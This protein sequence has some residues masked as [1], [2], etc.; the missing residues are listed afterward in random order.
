MSFSSEVKNEVRNNR[1]TTRKRHS[2]MSRYSRKKEQPDRERII[3]SFLKAGTVSDPG[4]FYHLEFICETEDEAAAL[5]EAIEGFG[6]SPGQM[7][8]KDREVLYFK[9][10]ESISDILVILGATNALLKLRDIMVL[11]EMKEYV[12]RRVNCET[13][14]IRKTVSASVR[15][16]EDIRLIRQ[17]HRFSDLPEGLKEAAELRMAYPEATLE[18]LASMLPG[19][20]RSGMNHRFRRLAKIAGELRANM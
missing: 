14:N 3:D 20:G 10:S 11:K 12:Q 7:R 1:F 18:E 13:A 6:L 9:D 4:K 17:H 19:T 15:Q 2:T 16:M 5:K 8:R